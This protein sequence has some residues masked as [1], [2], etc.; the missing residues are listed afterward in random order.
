MAAN[1][2]SDET[3]RSYVRV[4]DGATVRAWQW[5]GTRLMHLTGGID[6]RHFLVA[7]PGDWVVT[8]PAEHAV[9]NRY[10]ETDENFQAGYIELGVEP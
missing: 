6:G 10:R 5:N 1:A 2:T 7:E 3:E 4:A 8:E 9:F